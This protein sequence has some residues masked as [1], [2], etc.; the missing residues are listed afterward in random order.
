SEHGGTESRDTREGTRARVGPTTG[1]GMWGR[2]NARH[3]ARGSVTVGIPE[4]WF[5]TGTYAAP[6]WLAP[7]PTFGDRA[8]ID[9]RTAT[10]RSP[11]A[12]RLTVRATDRPGNSGARSAPSTSLRTR[13]VSECHEMPPH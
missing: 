9:H 6:K 10:I 13:P 3:P 7:H 8:P 5:R 1:S 11:T 2:R 12:G 4:W